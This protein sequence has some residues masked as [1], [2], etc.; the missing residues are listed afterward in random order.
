M[1]PTYGVGDRV[2]VNLDAYKTAK[3][4]RG[5]V[6]I[7][8]PPRGSAQSTCAN[9]KQPADGHP[10]ARPDGGEDS[11]VEFIK[12][13]VAIGGDEVKIV[14]NRTYVGGKQQDEPYAKVDGFCAELCNLPRPITIPDG[15]YFLLG[16][17]RAESSDSRVWGPVP[18]AWIVGRVTTKK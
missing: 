3:P 7:L 2:V 4:A 11:G 6:V 9:F 8:H 14:K 13:V 1:A 12:R 18:A 5:D 17:N 15:S 16:D 10:C